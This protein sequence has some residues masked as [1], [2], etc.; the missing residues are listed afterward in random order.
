M[1]QI[2]GLE[3]IGFL[4]DALRQVLVFDRILASGLQLQPQL[5]D[6]GKMFAVIV[7]LTERHGRKDLQD[8]CPANLTHIDQWAAQ[9]AH[10]QS[11]APHH[12]RLARLTPAMKARNACRRRL[13]VASAA[14]GNA[15]RHD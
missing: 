1:S 3:E 15:P 4:T 6:Q 2:A 5:A 7:R 14:V 11:R 10:R 8:V 9:V 13:S 12:M